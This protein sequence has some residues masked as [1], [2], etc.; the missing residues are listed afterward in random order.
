MKAIGEDRV[1]KPSVTRRT[2]AQVNIYRST[3]VIPTVV[4]NCKSIVKKTGK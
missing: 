2:F 1:Y 4:A 3:A